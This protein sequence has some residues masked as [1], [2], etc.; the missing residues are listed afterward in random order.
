MRSW[1]KEDLSVNEDSTDFVS[2]IREANSRLIERGLTGWTFQKISHGG[3]EFTEI[4]Q[5]FPFSA[6][7]YQN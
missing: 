7:P 5:G 2:G 1:L 3:T 4:I 6:I